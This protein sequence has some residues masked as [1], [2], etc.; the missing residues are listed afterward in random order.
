MTCSRL[1]TS[2]RMVGE[3]VLNAATSLMFLLS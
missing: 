1:S 2:A 3:M